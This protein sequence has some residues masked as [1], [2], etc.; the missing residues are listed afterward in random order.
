MRTL[1]LFFLA[2]LAVADAPSFF[3]P[4]GSVSQLM[5][6]MI[7]P[8]SDALFYV[9]RTPPATEKE[10]NTLRGTAL[11]LAESGNLLM[12]DPRARDQGDWMKDSKMLVDAGEAA[13]KAAQA[14]DLNAILALNDQLTASCIKCHV[15]YRPGYGKRR[16]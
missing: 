5:V 16:P 2:G 1:A 15:Q 3:K 7:Y 4:V 9:E 14:K 10:W 6:D 11:M 12:M 13:F 8:A